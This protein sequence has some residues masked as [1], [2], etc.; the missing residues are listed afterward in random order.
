MLMISGQEKVAKD[1]AYYGNIHYPGKNA[2]S[3]TANERLETRIHKK[4]NASQLIG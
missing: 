3:G 2:Q 4:G 1:G